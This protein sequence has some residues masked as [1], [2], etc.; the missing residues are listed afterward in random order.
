MIWLEQSTNGKPSRWEYKGQ[1]C[2]PPHAVGL[3]EETNKVAALKVMV[4]NVEIVCP[5]EDGMCAD[6]QYEV[7]EN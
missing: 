4:S 6:L 3:D 1:P 7:L 5:F 2:D